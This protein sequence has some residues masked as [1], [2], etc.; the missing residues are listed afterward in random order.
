MQ[1]LLAGHSIKHT[2]HIYLLGLIILVAVNISSCGNRGGHYNNGRIIEDS[3]RRKV[4]VPD[5]IKSVI[6]LRAGALR[7][8]CYMDMTDRVGYIEGNEK[9][10]NVPYL[11]AYPELKGK[12]IIG[13]GNNYDTELLAASNAGLIIAT[14]MGR[15]EADDLQKA[16]GKPV[17]VLE[18][19]DM[20]G[21]LE[22]LFNSIYLLGDLFY[23]QA[24]A[25]SLVQYI[26]NTIN[27]YKT[28]LEGND[29]V[30]AYTGGVAYRGAHGISST[31]PG[32]PPY[33]FLSVNNVAASLGEVV[34]SPLS[35]QENAFI[36]MEQLL[37]WDPDYIFLDAAGESIWQ[38]EI[39]KPVLKET[40]SSFRSKDVYSV[41]PYN[42]YTTNYENILCNTWFIGKTVYPGAFDD[43]DVGDKCREIYSFFLGK[44]VYDEMHELYRPFKQVLEEGE[45]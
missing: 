20:K 7:L 35:N 36:D 4:N 44:D 27:D 45:G 31:E 22:E 15:A 40:L 18:Y 14:Y 24:R 33:R 23:R 39:D 42:W 30:S 9:R 12:D 6:A 8:V 28:R 13:A 5:T 26:K 37:I 10:R 43:I 25:D 21:K 1:Y 3:E 32:Y 38:T 19:G 2:K 41:L 11:M 17:F 34:S 29:S 16:I